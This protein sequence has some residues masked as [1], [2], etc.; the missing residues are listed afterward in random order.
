[1]QVMRIQSTVDDID[2]QSIC[3]P[4]ESAENQGESLSSM[5][6]MN[7][8]EINDM[9]SITSICFNCKSYVAVL[10]NAFARNS[11]TTQT[12]NTPASETL[13]PVYL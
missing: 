8:Q 6:N 5:Q 10:L 2:Q 9:Y 4:F 11:S 12:N 13:P 7:S 3:P 1:M